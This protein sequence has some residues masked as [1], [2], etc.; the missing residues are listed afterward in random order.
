MLTKTA[1]DQGI[2]ASDWLKWVVFVDLWGDGTNDYE[3]SSFLPSS[4]GTFNDT[5]GNGIPD[6]YVSPTGQG[7]EIKITIPEDIV[8]SMSNHK[9]S[10]RVT[11]GC[12]NYRVCDQT[13]MVVDKKKPTPYCKSVSSALMVNGTVELWAVDFNVGSFDN[14]TSKDNLLYTFDEMHPALT[15]LNEVHIFLSLIHIS[16]PTRPY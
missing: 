5:N 2:C 10:W 7:G 8:G 6:R 13:F 3:F 4:D 16:E 14:C 12:G 15:K 9:V 1:T 11:D